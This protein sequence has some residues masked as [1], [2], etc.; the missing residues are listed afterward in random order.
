MRAPKA[1]RELLLEAGQSRLWAGI[2]FRSDIE[3]GLALGR[4][5]TKLVINRVRND[6][7]DDQQAQLVGGRNTK[8]RP[9]PGR[10]KI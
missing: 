1:A 7:A 3:T 10:F 8:M 4:G 6:G 9:P 2:H 5:V